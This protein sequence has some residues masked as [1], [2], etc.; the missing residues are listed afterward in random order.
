M[1]PFIGQGAALALAI[2]A[3]A[4]APAAWAADKSYEGITLNLASQNDQFAAVLAAVAPEFEAQTGAKE[5]GRAH[6]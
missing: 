5:I 1:K 3:S 2:L 6:V 4:G